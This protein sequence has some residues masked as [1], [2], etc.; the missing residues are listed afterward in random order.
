M[1]YRTPS[2]IL[3][4]GLALLAWGIVGY[5]AWTINTDENKRAEDARNA[6]LTAVKNAQA[7]RTHALVADAAPD[8]AKLK[9]LLNVDVVSASYMIESVGRA[10]GVK[11][12]LSDAQP[13][14]ETGTDILLQ[15]AVGFVVTAD[16]KFTELLH[17]VRLFESLPIPSSVTR[18]DIERAP[19]SPGTPASLWHLNVHIRVI[20]TAQI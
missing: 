19:K 10:A 12:R 7:V 5:F 13:E 4:L 11:M 16:G 15:R 18:L 20:T 8:S 2:A 1:R 3:V 14:G 6:Q 17:A 9:E